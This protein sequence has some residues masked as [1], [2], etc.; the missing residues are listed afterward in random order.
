MATS[1][2]ILPNNHVQDRMKPLRRHP[3]FSPAVKVKFPI[4]SQVAAPSD[5]VI[6]HRLNIMLHHNSSFY[7]R[8]S[9][10]VLLSSHHEAL[11]L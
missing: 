3:S 4:R 9:V 5:L 6:L 7:C 11:V 10:E 2:L 8:T 1:A